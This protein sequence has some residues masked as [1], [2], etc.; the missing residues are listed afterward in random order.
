MDEDRPQ[1]LR[2]KK[3]SVHHFGCVGLSTAAMT[4]SAVSVDEVSIHFSRGMNE[5]RW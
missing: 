5:R 4:L 3:R 2:E 1:Y